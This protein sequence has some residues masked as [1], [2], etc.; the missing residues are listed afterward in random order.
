MAASVRACSI[1]L[2]ERPVVIFRFAPERFCALKVRF[3][4]VGAHQVRSL[5][6][7]ITEIGP[8]QIGSPQV[9]PL[10]IGFFQVCFFEIGSV[11]IRFLKIG[12]AQL[13]SY[14][15]RAFEVSPAEIRFFLLPGLWSRSICGAVS[16]RP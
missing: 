14:K 15:N 10:E 2:L 4:E 12:L 6:I 16:G 1:W 9:R 3:V 8:A 11:E 5:Q 13:D 7:G